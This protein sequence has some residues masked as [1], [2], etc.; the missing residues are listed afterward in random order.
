MSK[1]LDTGFGQ[2]EAVRL[3]KANLAAKTATDAANVSITPQK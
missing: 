1:E 3:V 2:S